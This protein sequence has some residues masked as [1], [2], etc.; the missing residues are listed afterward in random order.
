MRI[1]EE[2]IRWE[3]EQER[4]G[5]DGKESRKGKDKMGWDRE[6]ERIG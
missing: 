6:Q 1:R 4:I 3:R 5:Y 2:G